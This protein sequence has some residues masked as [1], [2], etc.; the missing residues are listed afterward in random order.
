M[1][2]ARNSVHKPRDE[3]L[4]TRSRVETARWIAKGWEAA[5]ISVT[6]E[7]CGGSDWALIGT[8]DAD[9]SALPLRRDNAPDLW[10]CV[11]AYALECKDCGNMRI[12]SKA[13]IDLLAGS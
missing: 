10:R 8:D 5:G 3:R 1:A 4:G 13:R 12:M 11:L 6:C 2:A 7:L 9:G